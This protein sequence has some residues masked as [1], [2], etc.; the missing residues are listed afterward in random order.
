MSDQNSSNTITATATNPAFVQYTIA[1][2]TNSPGTVTMIA[3]TAMGLVPNGNSIAKDGTFDLLVSGTSPIAIRFSVTDGSLT[4]CAVVGIAMNLDSGTGPIRDAFPT[5]LINNTGLTLADH[6]PS[7][8]S[9][10]FYL[11]VQNASGQMGLIDPKI[12]NQ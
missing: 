7:T 2:F 6:N 3:P 4:P 1:P 8:A 5:A 11:L 12:T 10:D 9:Y